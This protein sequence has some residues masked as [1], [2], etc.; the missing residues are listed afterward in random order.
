ME[1]SAAGSSAPKLQET[2]PLRHARTDDLGDTKKV[3][4]LTRELMVLRPE[5]KARHGFL[6]IY[7]E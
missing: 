2:V 4:T 3:T 6:Y 5:T 1:P 7:T